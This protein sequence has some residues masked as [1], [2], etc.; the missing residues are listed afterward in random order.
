[1]KYMGGERR[2][3]VPIIADTIRHVLYLVRMHLPTCVRVCV[4]VCLDPEY[5]LDH[6]STQYLPTYLPNIPMHQPS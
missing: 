1:M 5:L 3:K 4:C 2:P 6:L